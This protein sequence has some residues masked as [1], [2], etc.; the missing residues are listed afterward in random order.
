MS[1][2]AEGRLTVTDLEGMLQKKLAE[3][4][5]G[6]SRDTVVKAKKAAVSEFNSRQT[7]TNDR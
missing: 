7:P 3:T 6:F 1:D 5:G 2:L 4:Y